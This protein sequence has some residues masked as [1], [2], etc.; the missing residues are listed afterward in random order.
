MAGQWSF[1]IGLR[2]WIA[3][4][5][6]YI[7]YKFHGYSCDNWKEGVSNESLDDGFTSTAD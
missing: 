7:K 5:D 2:V 1:I 6:K 4:G 3:V